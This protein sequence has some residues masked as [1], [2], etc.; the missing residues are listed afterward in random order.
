MSR[1]KNK[2]EQNI[3]KASVNAA[4]D[5]E[6]VIIYNP[7]GVRGIRTPRGTKLVLPGKNV[8]DPAVW[9]A[10]CETE[11][12]KKLVAAK[13]FRNLTQEAKEKEAAKKKADK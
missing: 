1:S 13:L 12:G 2:E 7:V 8:F 6:K 3:E 9:K 10:L 5:P 4:K 11:D